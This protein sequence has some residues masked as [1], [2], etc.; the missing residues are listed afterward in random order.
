SS[1][2]STDL[3]GPRSGRTRSCTR[4][5]GCASSWGAGRIS[6]PPRPSTTAGRGPASWRRRSRRRRRAPP[7]KPRARGARTK[8]SRG[9]PTHRSY[10]AN[11]MN[12]REFCDR[13]A[14]LAAEAVRD[15]YSHLGHGAVGYPAFGPGVVLFF[16]NVAS[17]TEAVLPIV[18]KL[19][20]YLAIE[21]VGIR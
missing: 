14:G 16:G 17:A 5:A 7:E 19:R 20:E 3:A 8:S 12:D 1:G 21:E 4:G 10:R 18:A 13:S 6:A 2:W 9:H 11:P 15:K